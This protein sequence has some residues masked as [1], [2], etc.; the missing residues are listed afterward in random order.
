MY[1]MRFSSFDLMAICSL[2]ERLPAAT[3]RQSW[4]E[5]A[6]TKARL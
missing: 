5:A 1:S 3:M 2:K 6:P 4:L